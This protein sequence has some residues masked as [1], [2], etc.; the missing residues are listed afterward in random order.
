[1]AYI[2]AVA[3]DKPAY[4]TYIDWWLPM[5]IWAVAWILGAA[6]LV[7]ATV[8]TRFAIPAMSIFVGMTSVWAASYLI[9]WVFLDSP[10]SWLTGSTL[11]GMAVFA[12]IL[13]A[14]IERRAPSPEELG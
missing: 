13:T 4:L 14:L 10:S 1:M 8:W 12:A 11:A 5:H 2:P 6:A 9:S 7:A 3:D